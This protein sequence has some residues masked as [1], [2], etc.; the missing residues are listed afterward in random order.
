MEQTQAI[1]GGPT[2]AGGVNDENVAVAPEHLR[3][4]ADRH[5]HTLPGLVRGGDFDTRTCQRDRVPHGG[6]VNILLAVAFPRPTRPE[7]ILLAVLNCHDG[8][9]NRPTQSLQ[10]SAATVRA[11][12]VTGFG[13]QH[14]HAVV[15]IVPIVGSEV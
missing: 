9:V 3:P 15:L 11:A 1:I 12:R 8:A 14:P 7:E 4:L 6:D 13:L 2:S 5:G 10:W